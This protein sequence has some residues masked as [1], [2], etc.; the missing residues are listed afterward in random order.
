MRINDKEV[1]G[2]AF[3]FDG[4]HKIYIIEDEEDEVQAIEY[5]YEIYD[6]SQIKKIWK[7]SCSL[8][9]ISN[10]KLD[11]RYVAQFENARFE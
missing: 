6:I 9:F 10:W 11:I 5:G 4:C 1:K 8:R 7:E 2:N 3:A